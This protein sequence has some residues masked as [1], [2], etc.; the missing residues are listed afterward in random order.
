MDNIEPQVDP[1]IEDALAEMRRDGS[2][3][4]EKSRLMV[5][6]WLERIYPRMVSTET[7][8]ST[9]VEI[10]KTLIELGDLKPKKD[11]AVAATGPAFSITIQLPDTNGG[12]PITITST[13]T[14]ENAEY[15]E[16]ETLDDLP[17]APVNFN[18]PS[19]ALNSDLTSLP[20]Q[21]D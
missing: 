21:E 13:T 20:P 14:P 8:T 15:T 16:V 10:G 17:P 5:E 4:R 19:F 11:L 7:P 2:L 12:K 18:L 6:T 9:L 3:I 1:E